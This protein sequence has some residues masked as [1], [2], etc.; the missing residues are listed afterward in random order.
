MLDMVPVAALTFDEG[1]NSD[2]LLFRKP[3]SLRG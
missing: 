2:V 1:E 3:L